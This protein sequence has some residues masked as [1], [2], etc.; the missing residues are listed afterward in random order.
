MRKEKKLLI[1][2]MI[3]GISS[4]GSKLLS[5]IILPIYATYF[6]T[7]EF[8]E[9]DLIS[10]TISLV[11]PLISL[12]ITSGLYR[13]L[14]ETNN[15]EDKEKIITTCGFYIIR[16]IGIFSV[17]YIFINLYITNKYKLL[18]Y[19]MI[20]LAQLEDYILKILRGCLKNKEF[21]LIGVLKSI[22]S[23]IMT[24]IFIYIYKL[25]LETFIYI[26][27]INSVISILGGIYFLKVW[28]YI[29]KKE[30]S[31]KLLTEIKKY[32]IPLIP[33]NV[34]WWIMNL[35][36]RYIIVFI[37][38]VSINGI[39]AMANKF[40]SLLAIIN[41]IFFMAWQDNAL[42]EAPNKYKYEYY[43][44][45]FKYY[46]KLMFLGVTILIVI[47]RQVIIYFLDD[48][49]KEVWKY[50]NILYVASLFSFFSSFWG[51][52]FH[53][54]KKTSIILQTTFIGAVINIIVNII[55]IKYIGLYAACISTLVCYLIMWILRINYLK[56]NTIKINKRDFGIMLILLILSIIVSYKENII[57]EIGM[58]LFTL[59]IYFILNKHTF[60]NI[61]YI[62][63]KYV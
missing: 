51:I 16:N 58:L 33:G 56:L 2:M 63:K 35:S 60:K 6:T 39:Y 23:F 14:I 49:Y 29:K 40:P 12:E 59:I 5:F 15:K 9:W 52:A 44:K 55:F 27:I 34:N 62:I 30:Y 41:T 50:T 11:S 48:N 18:I 45:V 1:D 46:S 17:I 25:R 61:F 26:A 20:I 42:K 36:D 28:Q 8:G 13:W 37:L 22:L 21:A 10:T 4:M 43:S 53:S 19:L 24:F 7:T 54:E 38:G 3:Y 57:L 47:N 31:K 32:S